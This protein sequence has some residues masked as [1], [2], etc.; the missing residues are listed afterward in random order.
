MSKDNIKKLGHKAEIKTEI[1][2]EM[3]R[4]KGGHVSS[5]PPPKPVKPEVKPEKK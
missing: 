1:K 5:A 2:V 3:D 4:V